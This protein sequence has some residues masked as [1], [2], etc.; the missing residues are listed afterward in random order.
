MIRGT[1]DGPSSLPRSRNSILPLAPLFHLAGVRGAGCNPE[2]RAKS[3]KVILDGAGRS[4][5]SQNPV[6]MSYSPAGHRISAGTAMVSCSSASRLLMPR[7]W[8]WARRDAGLDIASR[9]PRRPG[10]SEQ[11]LK[12]RPASCLYMTSACSSRVETSRR[13]HSQAGW[14]QAYFA[15]LRR[16]RWLADAIPAPLNNII[17]L[18]S[19]LDKHLF[20]CCLAG[21]IGLLRHRCRRISPAL[22]LISLS[23]SGVYISDARAP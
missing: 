16:L 8:R 3:C 7:R 21:G 20:V 5:Y 17:S 22:L 19:S 12:T 2:R 23:S 15:P 1:P 13:R 10:E 11:R 14:L 6:H 18:S 4:Y 9:R